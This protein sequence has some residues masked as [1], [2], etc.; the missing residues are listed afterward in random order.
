MVYLRRAFPLKKRCVVGQVRAFLPAPR[1]VLRQDV[2]GCGNTGSQ[3][4]K[5][6]LSQLG[7]LCSRQGSSE[8]RTFHRELL[9][10]CRGVIFGWWAGAI[11]GTPNHPVEVLTA[12][13]SRH[14]IP[15]PSALPSSIGASTQPR[16]I[17]YNTLFS[18]IL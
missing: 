14:T 3:V 12:V 2:S 4:S 13:V 10:R 1:A 15:T 17:Q 6:R 5:S 8:T 16:L 18:H 9:C 7:Q 11:F